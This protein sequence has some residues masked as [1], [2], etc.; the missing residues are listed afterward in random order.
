MVL[1]PAQ[2]VKTMATFSG[3]KPLPA[4]ASLPTVSAQRAGTL[5]RR[6]SLA[7][8]SAGTGLGSGPSA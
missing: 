6:R 2:E 1:S 3:L 7:G 8:S 4:S 5:A